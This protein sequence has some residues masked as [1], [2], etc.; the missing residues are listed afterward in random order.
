MG[1]FHQY[2]ELIYKSQQD[3]PS[4]HNARQGLLVDRG[5]MMT[6]EYQRPQP[7]EFVEGELTGSLGQRHQLTDPI[8]QG[9]TETHLLTVKLSP[10]EITSSLDWRP[11]R[12]N[13]PNISFSVLWVKVQQATKGIKM[14][15]LQ[16]LQCFASV[17][18]PWQDLY[19]PGLD[20]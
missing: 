18:C 20:Q 13:I 15:F 12:H 9:S 2:T 16:Q 3:P 8:Q 7:S 6:D 11:K 17:Q 14:N 4:T 1:P 19:S 10:E 5:S